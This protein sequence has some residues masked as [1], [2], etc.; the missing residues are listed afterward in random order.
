MV[1]LKKMVHLRRRLFRRCTFGNAGSGFLTF[2]R[3]K[4]AVYERGKKSGLVGTK[5][6]QVTPERGDPS[7]DPCGVY[8]TFFFHL[9][10]LWGS[11]LCQQTRHT[12]YMIGTLR[13][14][15]CCFWSS[16]NTLR[17]LWA[18]ENTYKIHTL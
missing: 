7:A 11:Y 4:Q 10:P 8:Q 17:P 14:P 6:Y 13:K 2:R 5:K 15:V 9:R 12:G 3:G 1:Y 16:P 18:R